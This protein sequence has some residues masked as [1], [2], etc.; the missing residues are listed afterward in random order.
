MT[1]LRWA[2]LSDRGRV[3]ERNEDRWSVDA[4][5][6]LF[7]VS[8]GMGGRPAGEVASEVVVATLPTLVAT[9]LGA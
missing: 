6:G 8:D 2:G 4:D 5:L 1:A 3:R 7:I 9:H